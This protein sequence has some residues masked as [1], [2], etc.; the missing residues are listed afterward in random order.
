M[1]GLYKMMRLFFRH[2]YAYMT[3]ARH[4][5]SEPSMSMTAATSIPRYRLHSRSLKVSRPSADTKKRRCFSVLTFNN[6]S[7]A[8][9]SGGQNATPA[10]F[11]YRMPGDTQFM[12][13]HGGPLATMYPAASSVP[14][15]LP[16]HLKPSR[17]LADQLQKRGFPVWGSRKFVQLQHPLSG[18]TFAIPASNYAKMN[19]SRKQYNLIPAGLIKHW[20]ENQIKRYIKLSR[21]GGIKWSIEKQRVGLGKHVIEVFQPTRPAAAAPAKRKRMVRSPY[22][23]RRPYRLRPRA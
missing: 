17:Q 2:S 3:R 1:D 6:Q 19:A 16:R 8:N 12:C 22:M 20:D 9:T 13:M 5:L 14:N 15:D 11:A 18:R 4:T 23:L 10:G 21:T 7:M